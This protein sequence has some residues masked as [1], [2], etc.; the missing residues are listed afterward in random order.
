LASCTCII[1][2]LVWGGSTYPWKSG[3]IIAL[4]IIGPLL[5]ALFILIE[6]LFEKDNSSRAPAFLRPIFTHGTPMIPLEIFKDWD[7]TIC[8]WCNLSGGMVMYGQFYYIAI[9]FT[10]VFLYPPQ[11]AGKQLLYFLPGLGIGVWSAMFFILK[12]FHGTKVI[13]IAGSIV[14]SVATGLFSTAVLDQSKVKLYVFMAM[15]GV[16]VGLV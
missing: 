4:L 7:V 3:R 13:L 14:M 10:I 11:Q 15:M 1:L 9:Y 5:L 16:G 12:V 2:A 8:Q 6:W